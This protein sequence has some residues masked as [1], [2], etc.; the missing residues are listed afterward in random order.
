MGTDAVRATGSSR[1]RWIVGL[2]ILALVVLVIVHIIR[3]REAPHRGEPATVVG[4]SAA[5][6]G[7]MPVDIDGLLGTVT[8]VA[9]V[10]VLP[11]L[12][13]YLTEVAYH[14]GEEVKKG[15]LLAQIDPRQYEI[16]KREA[17]ATLAKDQAALASAKNDLSRYRA[18]HGKHSIAEQTYT[19]QLYTV[20]QDEAAV[21]SDQAA[22]D[23]YT[24]DLEY[25]RITAPVAGRVGLRLVDPGNYVTA[26]STTGIV[27]ITTTQ[28]TTVEFPVPQNSMPA[29]L[30]RFRAGHTLTVSAYDS[31]ND[32]KLA[33]GTLYS[34]GNQMDTSTGTVTLRAS[35]PNRDDSLYPDEFVN[36]VLHVDTMQHAVLIPTA[37]VQNGA[38]GD[39]VYLVN[40]NQTVSVH[41][42]K[43]GPSDGT[44]TVVLSG[45]AVGQQVVTD[46][47]DRLADGTHIRLKQARPAT[48]TSA[49]AASAS[50]TK[51]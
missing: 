29:V 10:T 15:Q 28:A 5:Q 36:I 27:V 41:P 20:Q 46:G 23:Q 45:L 38:P 30:Q 42:V 47:V 6:L 16:S 48:S 22:I 21:K 44:H 11:Q 13:G 40:S 17:E 35:F 43:L 39:F 3:N 12:S 33:D 51:S 4:A 2:I 8:P 18:L 49:A 50:A 26:S 34:L 1:G 31:D 25:C 19:D 32:K 14:E 7:D 37:A 9:T 24:L